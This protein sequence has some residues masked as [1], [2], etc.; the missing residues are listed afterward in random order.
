MFYNI[1]LSMDLEKIR[2]IK[3]ELGNKICISK[4]EDFNL[5]YPYAID[6]ED[7]SFYYPNPEE[8]DA[9]FELLIKETN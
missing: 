1:D 2:G 5:T 4:S 9:D 8:R 3:N 7:F 6:V